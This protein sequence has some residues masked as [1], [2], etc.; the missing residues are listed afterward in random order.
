MIDGNEVKEDSHYAQHYYSA[1]K[2][3][4]KVYPDTETHI[5]DDC[6]TTPN[7]DLANNEM[8]DE[9]KPIPRISINDKQLNVYYN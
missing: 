7:E 6:M 1:D 9:P 8:K 3:C 5:Y 2:C 4:L